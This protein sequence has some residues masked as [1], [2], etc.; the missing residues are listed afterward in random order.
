MGKKEKGE[1]VVETSNELE[2][3]KAK[4]KLAL[5]LTFG[6]FVLSIA[7]A[8]LSVIVCTRV[9]RKNLLEQIASDNCVI[10]QGISDSI[11]QKVDCTVY[12]DKLVEIFKS[13]TK[14]ELDDQYA[15][16]YYHE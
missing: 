11:S 2:F 6:V 12:A 7:F 4:G 10:A 8:V 1:E 5:R 15:E 3:K 13:M 14:A 9:Y 16:G